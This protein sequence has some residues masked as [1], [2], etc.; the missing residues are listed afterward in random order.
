[1]TGP[2]T[3]QTVFAQLSREHE[4]SEMDRAIMRAFEQLLD[5]RPEITDG[6]V[7][8]VNIAAE[9]GVSRASYYRSPVAGAI[10]EILTAPSTRRPEVDEL[11]AEVIRLRK[12]LRDL[13]REK[14]SEVRDLNATAT[15][16]A[17]QIQVLALRNA[18]L[19]ADAATL[20]GQITDATS[21]TVRPLRKP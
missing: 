14:A 10:K 11:K 16:Y 12:E 13:R 1:M 3:T 9:A 4:L 19:E 6:S 18:E 2:R 20:R 7:H 21:G 8:V 17:N 5:G 15:T